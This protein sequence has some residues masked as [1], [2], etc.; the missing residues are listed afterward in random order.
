MNVRILLIG[1]A[2]LA[3]LAILGFLG[4]AVVGYV[5]A[6]QLTRVRQDA[7]EASTIGT[8]RTILSAQFTYSAVCAQGS[9]APTFDALVR[10]GPGQAMGYL[11]SDLIGGQ[12]V[13]KAGYQI[14]MTGVENPDAT[15]SCNSVPAGKSL[16][17]FSITAAP[18]GGSGRHFGTNGEGTIY[19][20]AS[21]FVMPVTGAPN[22]AVSVP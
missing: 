2:A 16:R 11:S 3:G 14:T 22:G 9:F 6:P 5:A 10:P 21:S 20:S 17:A 7:N 19:Q 1:L 8:L 12:S 13:M 18:E 15:A 4:L